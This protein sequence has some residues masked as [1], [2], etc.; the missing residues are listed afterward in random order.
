MSPLTAEKKA[1][2]SAMSRYNAD[3]RRDGR[4]IHQKRISVTPEATHFVK[5]QSRIAESRRKKSFYASKPENLGATSP[6]FRISDN[7]VAA[8]VNPGREDPTLH[9]R[10]CTESGKINSHRFL[11]RSGVL[12]RSNRRHVR[13]RNDGRRPAFACLKMV[14]RDTHSTRA[15]SSDVMQRPRRCPVTTCRSTGTGV[16]YCVR[17][18]S[19]RMVWARLRRRCKQVWHRFIGGC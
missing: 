17:D 10:Y 8:G 14:K 9:P 19:D 5:E 11:S 3:P 18:R 6:R 7:R 1:M 4:K 13:M 12:L 15:N 16:F 2:A